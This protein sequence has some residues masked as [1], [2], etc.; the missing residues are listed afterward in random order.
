M[1]FIDKIKTKR[2]LK[3]LVGYL[4]LKL[5]YHEAGHFV[6][7][8]ILDFKSTSAT[9]KCLSNI[10]FVNQNGQSFC[11]LDF[12]SFSQVVYELDSKIDSI[13]NN[14]NQGI[15]RLATSLNYSMDD[16]WEIVLRYLIVLL[17][18]DKTLSFFHKKILNQELETL[19][20]AYAQNLTGFD[21]NADRNKMTLLLNNLTNDAN[22]K[23]EIVK[24]AY[25]II[26]EFL[27]NKIVNKAIIR[28]SKELRRKVQIQEP[29]LLELKQD[30][31]L[32]EETLKQGILDS[33]GKAN[34]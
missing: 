34:A 24:N 32:N 25:S 20:Q 18:G 9:I 21:I 11:T 12:Q 30:L 6:F 5:S 17:A 14:S 3:K 29:E 23:N 33:I 16:I 31:N 4:Q 19:N 26:E 8:S 27:N 13:L 22:L 1:E 15:N 2:K 7:A 28:V 10:E